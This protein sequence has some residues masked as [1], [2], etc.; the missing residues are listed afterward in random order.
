[1][2]YILK[3]NTTVKVL[4]SANIR[5]GEDLM[6]FYDIIFGII[7]EHLMSMLV[8]TCEIFDSPTHC[9]RRIRYP[10]RPGDPPIQLV[11]YIQDN[12]HPCAN[13]RLLLNI[14]GCVRLVIPGDPLPEESVLLRFEE[15][16][17]DQVLLMPGEFLVSVMVCRPSQGVENTVPTGVSFLFKVISGE[18]MDITRARIAQYNYADDKIIP[19]VSFQAQRRLLNDNEVVG[20]FLRP[21]EILRIVLP[22]RARFNAIVRESRKATRKAMERENEN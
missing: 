21:G 7:P 16:P 13:A 8:R 19:W 5:R 15:V 9:A 17:P 2:P 11:R 14:D 4:F 22:D 3:P 10:M 6:L 18:T 1:M 20:T 12:F